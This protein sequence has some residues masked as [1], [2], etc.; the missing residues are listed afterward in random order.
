MDCTTLDIMAA[1]S[2]DLGH[3][4]AGRTGL[5]R[6]VEMGFNSIKNEILDFDIDNIIDIN[7][8]NLSGSLSTKLSQLSATMN[9]AMSG[10][11]EFV[12]HVQS[13]MDN[14]TDDLTSMTSCNCIA[15]QLGI[16]TSNPINVPDLGPV[17]GKSFF[18]GASAFFGSVM[19][20]GKAILSDVENIMGDVAENVQLVKQKASEIEA[21]IQ[22]AKADLILT[23][24]NEIQSIIDE[25]GGTITPLAQEDIDQ[26]NAAKISAQS[27]ATLTQTARQDLINAISPILPN[28]FD[29]SGVMSEISTIENELDEFLSSALSSVDSLFSTSEN[30]NQLVLAEQQLKSSALKFMSDISSASVL[31]SLAQNPEVKEVLGSIASDDLL[32]LLGKIC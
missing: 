13:K 24:D 8:V 10:F 7:S 5:A 3:G 14:I 25:A 16:D 11:A 6:D 30:A 23:I 12:S 32:N 26:L 28:D 19:D 15:S 17:T 29:F 27:F 22:N 1:L 31:R 18:G 2:S 20:E 4:G 21:A 9:S